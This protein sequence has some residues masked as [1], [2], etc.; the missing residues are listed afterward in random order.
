MIP[1]LLS[2]QGAR[3]LLQFWPLAPLALLVFALSPHVPVGGDFYWFYYKVPQDWLAGETRLYDDASRGYFLPPW[4]IWPYLPLA[5]LDAFLANALANTIAAVIIGAIAYQQSRSLLIGLLAAACPYSL[6]LYLTGTP[7]AWSL[8]GLWLAWRASQRRNGWGLGAGAALALVRPQNCLLTMP[9]LFRG[10]RP[11]LPKAGAV[12]ALVLVASTF[13][14][15]PDW[16]IRWAENY[17]IRPP[18]PEGAATT[19]SALERIGV[20]LWASGIAGLAAAVLVFRRWGSP[21]HFELLVAFNT[22]LT[23]FI[24]SPGYVLL[25]A[26]PWAGLAVRRPWP[27]A[28]VYAISLPTIMV[29]AFWGSLALVW[30]YLPYFDLL[31]PIALASALLFE[32]RSPVSSRVL[33]PIPA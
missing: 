11:A 15:G 16:P 4:G 3:R 19:Y 13:V 26:I 27:A 29:P 32:K 31:F 33:Q 17:F 22:I 5:L 23:P 25:L 1:A 21:E 14:S 8:L 20:P 9:A 18:S 24:R 28:G 12:L 7:D 2:A 30:P 6:V 10:L